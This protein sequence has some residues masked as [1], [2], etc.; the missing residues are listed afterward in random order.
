MK[1]EMQEREGKQLYQ[2]AL[3]VKANVIVEIGTFKGHS[4][5]WFLKALEEL[6]QGIL[7]TV[8]ITKP[9]NYDKLTEAQL[10]ANHHEATERLKS[11]SDRFVQVVDEIN[12][13]IPDVIDILFVDGNHTMEA[14]YQDLALYYPKVKSGGLCL[15]HDYHGIRVPAA[16]ASYFG[17]VMPKHD[18]LV[19]D[20][21]KGD[22]LIIYKD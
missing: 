15:I 2:M 17:A 5:S 14:C 4:G 8:D 7:I 6:G 20:Q 16:V 18:L 11:V 21:F 10:T 3:D 13:D 22:L 9:V 12:P 1:W 19:D